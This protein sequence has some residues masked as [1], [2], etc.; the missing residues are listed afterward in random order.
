[1][2]GQI[3]TELVRNVRQLYKLWWQIATE[4]DW[5]EM[6]KQVQASINSCVATLAVPRMNLGESRKLTTIPDGNPLEMEPVAR[7][8]Q[9]NGDFGKY[10]GALAQ[11]L[12]ADG[13]LVFYL[14]RST[15]ID[16]MYGGQSQALKD[17]VAFA[18]VVVFYDNQDGRKNGFISDLLLTRQCGILI[19]IKPK[20]KGGNNSG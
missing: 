20:F 5:A 11:K 19:V 12:A 3:Q 9:I 8:P 16:A 2:T 10:A 13:H 15:A 4:E 18:P 17:I 6:Q 14:T 7:R 1:M